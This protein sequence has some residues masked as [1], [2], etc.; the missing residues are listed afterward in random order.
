MC[1]AFTILVSPVI[2]SNL[3]STNPGMWSLD[4]MLTWGFLYSGVLKMT[5]YS[6]GFTVSFGD[7]LPDSI[8]PRNLSSA[9]EPE[10][11]R[12]ACGV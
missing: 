6:T 8:H 1:I 3:F 10:T 9:F 7:D 5:D 4:V 12:D 2:I 11:S